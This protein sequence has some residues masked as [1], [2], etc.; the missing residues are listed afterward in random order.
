MTQLIDG[1]RICFICKEEITD[2]RKAGYVSGY[3]LPIMFHSEC[4]QNFEAAILEHRGGGAEGVQTVQTKPLH[5]A[6]S[7]QTVIT[8]EQAKEKLTKVLMLER[9]LESEN[10]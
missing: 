7:K 8:P 3:G 1:M 10:N 4:G 5:K 6:E 2:M 9:L